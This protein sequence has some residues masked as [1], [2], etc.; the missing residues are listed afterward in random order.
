[1]HGLC[2]AV[3]SIRASGGL[4][5]MLVSGWVQKRGSRVRIPR[6]QVCVCGGGGGARHGTAR[7]GA[8]RCGTVRCGAV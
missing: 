8:V 2:L 7:H 6:A 4:V 3:R 1:M 5:V